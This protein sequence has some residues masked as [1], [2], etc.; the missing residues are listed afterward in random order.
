MKK[1]Y[2]LLVFLAVPAF[3]QESRYD[4]IALGP[5][6]PVP[7]ASI[8][9]CTQPANTSTT[10][11]SPLANLCSSLT[12]VVCTQPNPVTADSL[13]N[14]HFYYKPTQTPVTIQI[15][16]PQ[17]ASPVVYPDQIPAPGTLVSNNTWTGNNTFSGTVTSCSYDGVSYVGSGAPYTTCWGSSDIGAQINAAYAACP[18]SGC[19]I[20]VTPGAYSYTTPIVFG[21]SNKGALLTCDRGQVLQQVPT[22]ITTL[23]FTPTSG[24]A[25]TFNEGPGGMDGC[26]VIGTGHAGTTG[27]ALTYIR[28][29]T[30]QND[31]ISNFDIGLNCTGCNLAAQFFVNTF[32]NMQVHDN[33]TN[34]LLAPTGGPGAENVVFFGGDFY[35][36]TAAFSTTCIDIG[37]GVEFSFYGTSFDQCGMTLRGTGATVNLFH[38]HFENPNG[39]TTND[40]IT[41]AANCVQCILNLHGGKFLEDSS[42]ARTEFI[43]NLATN[44]GGGVNYIFVNGAQFIP[45]ENVAQCLRAASNVFVQIIATSHLINSNGNGF[46][47]NLLYNSNFTSEYLGGIMQSK[48]GT[49]G[50]TTGGAAGNNCASAITVTWPLGFGDTNYSATCT[51]QGTPT[52]APSGPYVVSKANGSI[53]VNYFA[54]TAA[55]ASYPTVD[56]VAVHD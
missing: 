23:T 28:A 43:S 9:V 34:N 6:G 25:I 40:F 2:W 3:A 8:A 20:V 24:T 46:T 55:A 22:G 15:Y 45:A 47:C 5:K 44:G 36:K 48:R 12:D 52:N 54:I 32:I 18:S 13:G 27:V 16:G 14:F 4:G 29:S 10:P 19:H 53:T 11:C 7:G 39:S 56:C 42:S 1:W 50:C 41:L 30:F 37:T 51:G 49:A 35:T 21:N 38:G 31:D 33:L 17:V 26:I